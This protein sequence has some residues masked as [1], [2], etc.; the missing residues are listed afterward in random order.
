MFSFDILHLYP[1]HLPNRTP[2]YNRRQWGKKRT[3]N[4][5]QKQKNSDESEQHWCYYYYCTTWDSEEKVQILDEVS[6]CIAHQVRYSSLWEE[7]PGCAWWRCCPQFGHRRS[8]CPGSPCW[9]TTSLKL[10]KEVLN[11]LLKRYVVESIFW[12]GE[13]THE[14]NSHFIIEPGIGIIIWKHCGRKVF[15][16]IIARTKGYEVIALGIGLLPVNRK[17]LWCPP[18]SHWAWKKK[19]KCKH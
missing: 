13:A 2:Q 11:S 17:S 19:T 6:F 5:P 1:N 3:S 9:Q 18:E 10:N 8:G 4:S 15:F 16:C 14:L 12:L 7:Q